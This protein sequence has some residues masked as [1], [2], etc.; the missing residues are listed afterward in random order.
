MREIEFCAN[1]LLLLGGYKNQRNSHSG[2]ARTKK[3]LDR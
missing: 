1:Q 2:Q 3:T